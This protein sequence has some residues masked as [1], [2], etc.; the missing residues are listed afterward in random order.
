MCSSDLEIDGVNQFMAPHGFGTP[1]QIFGMVARRHM[2]EYGT[3]QEQFGAVALAMRE[4]AAL[5]ARAMRR[6]PLGMDEYLASRIIADPSLHA[7]LD[8]A[9]ALTERRIAD[10][11]DAATRRA[12]P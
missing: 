1:A 10:N 9:R 6:E 11:A 4:Q 3:T 8:D 12:R 2:H 5:N 7:L